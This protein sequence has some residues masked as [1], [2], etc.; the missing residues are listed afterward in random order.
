V[1]VHERVNGLVLMRGVM[2]AGFTGQISRLS[3]LNEMYTLTKLMHQQNVLR[4]RIGI[5]LKLLGNVINFS[6]IFAYYVTHI[7]P[8]NACYLPKSCVCTS[9]LAFAM[10]GNYSS[11]T[12][13]HV[14]LYKYV[15]ACTHASL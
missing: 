8:T 14:V 5:L 10:C 11:H 6:F 9:T 7:N 3:P 4:G 1:D 13:S 15:C 2:V 12:H